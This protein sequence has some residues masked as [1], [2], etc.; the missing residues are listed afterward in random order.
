MELTIPLWPR[1]HTPLGTAFPPE[2]KCSH[3]CK[4][5]IRERVKG[6]KLKADKKCSSLFKSDG[7]KGDASWGQVTQ[8]GQLEHVTASLEPVT[9]TAG[10]RRVWIQ[11]AFGEREQK[12]HQQV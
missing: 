6:R 10:T 2:K 11:D 4:N 5:N 8:E 12:E 3:P 9:L 1:W 7:G